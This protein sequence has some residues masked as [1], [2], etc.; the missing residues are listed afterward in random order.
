MS[1]L[2]TSD[3]SETAANNNAAA[4]NGAPEGMTAASLN[5]TI[6]EI[7]SAVKIW[8]N[9]VS[10][11]VIAGGTADA[12]TLTYGTAPPSYVAGMRFAFYA[13]AASNTGA[14]TLNVNGLGVKSIVRRDGSTALSAADITANAVYEVVYD[15]TN[16]RLMQTG[17]T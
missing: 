17:I 4:P 12:L 1:Q 15:G 11:T 2:Q 7:M 5:N 8:Y 10:P 9:R 13:G 16:F 3:W 6:R 14:A